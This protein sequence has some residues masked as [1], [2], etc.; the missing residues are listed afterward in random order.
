MTRPASTPALTTTVEPATVIGA[1][2]PAVETG[3]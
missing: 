3:L 1:T 2:V